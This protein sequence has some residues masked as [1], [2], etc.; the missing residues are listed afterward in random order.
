MET[1]IAHWRSLI[2][3]AVFAL[4]CVVAT[5]IVY[6]LFGGSLPLEAQGYRVN[7]PA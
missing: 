6:H 4:A 7:V 1:R 2:V 5:L 3:P